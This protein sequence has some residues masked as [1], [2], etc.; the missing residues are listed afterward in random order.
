[1]LK[2]ISNSANHIILRCSILAILKNENAKTIEFSYNCGH[3]I[4]PP[5]NEEVYIHYKERLKNLETF[6]QKPFVS[7]LTFECFLILC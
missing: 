2:T 7:Q 5:L 3:N 1:M 4:Q 6:K